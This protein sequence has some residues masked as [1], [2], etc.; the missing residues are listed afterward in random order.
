MLSAG[1]IVEFIGTAQLCLFKQTR[2][3]REEH[4]VFVCSQLT[5]IQALPLVLQRFP[6]VKLVLKHHHIENY[7]LEA[8]AMKQYGSWRPWFNWGRD[9]VRRSAHQARTLWRQRRIETDGQVH[10][11]PTVEFFGAGRIVVHAGAQLQ[12]RVVLI[13]EEGSTIE[14]GP[15][16]VVGES[17]WLVARRGRALRLGARSTLAEHVWLEAVADISLGNSVSINRYTE[18]SPREPQ[19][20]GALTIGDEVHIQNNTI[21]DLSAEVVIESQVRLG[22]YCAIYTHNHVPAGDASIWAQNI[23]RAAVH[24][25]SGAWIGQACI[26]LAGVDVGANA[27]VAAGAVVT[28]AV[29]A[30]VTVGGVP[31]RP[32]Q[33]KPY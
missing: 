5:M 20:S 9:L 23:E 25:G 13:D 14:V 1:L 16:T 31:A 26:L 12:R 6:G 3:W 11:A 17:S 21:I 30:G 10:I 19:V 27:V 2:W 7:P 29:P 18:I 24:I 15:Q 8:Q 33:A 4:L 28:R 32:L 22:P